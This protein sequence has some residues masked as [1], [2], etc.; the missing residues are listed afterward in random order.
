MFIC[1]P[2]INK[3]V[4]EWNSGLKHCAKSNTVNPCGSVFGNKQRLQNEIN[5]KLSDDEALCA[6]RNIRKKIE[7]LAW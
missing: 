7:A 5:L 1:H 2:G 3:K 4:M 6:C